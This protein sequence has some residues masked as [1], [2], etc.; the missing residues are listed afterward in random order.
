MSAGKLASLL[1]ATA[2]LGCGTEAPV[3]D[4]PTWAQDVQPILRAHC[5]HCHG[6]TASYKLYKTMRWDVFDLGEEPYRRMGFEKVFEE[7]AQ[8]S[9]ELY[10]VATF[11]GANDASHG[12]FINAYVDVEAGAQRMPP[13]PALPLSARDRTVLQRWS[14]LLKRQPALPAS[15]LKGTH[16]P[17]HLPTL[18]WLQSPALAVVA[19]EDGDQVLGKLDC[20]GVELRIQRSGGLTFPEGTKPPCRGTLY[21]GYEEAP[22]SLE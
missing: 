3:P 13:P 5:F 10:K 7:V 4:S 11:F 8:Q 6:P 2:A 17:N 20:G 12:G 21:D 22:V 16:Q 15:A 18:A 19:D 1:S 9:G 14:D